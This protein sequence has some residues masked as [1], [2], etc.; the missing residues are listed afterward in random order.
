MLTPFEIYLAK[1]EAHLKHGKA[2][3]HTYR[4]ALENLVGTLTEH[5]RIF[6]DPKHI[7]CGAPDFVVERQHVPLGYIETKNIGEDLDKVEK[8]GQL[9]RYRQALNNLVLTDYLEFR[10]YVNGQPKLTARIA[11]RQPN[12]Q[13]DMDRAGVARAQQ[14]FREFFQ[15][16]APTVAS[17]R[18]LAE[19]M[20]Q[21]A[22]LMRDLIV[23][24]LQADETPAG[25]WHQQYQI[26]QAQLLPKLKPREFADIYAQTMAYGL[27]AAWASMPA[28][29][30]FS[31]ASAY[32]YLA[33]NR[34]L[35]KLFLD[36]GEEMEG[37]LLAPFLDDV[38]A[39]LAHTAPAVLQ[40]FGK[41]PH[42]EDP[43]VHFYETFLAAYDPQ[44]RERRGVYYTPEPAVLFIVNS[45]QALLK[46][47]L[48]RAQGLADKDVFLLDPA[49][50]TSTFLYFVARAVHDSLAEKKQLG[51]W[52]DYVHTNLLPRLIGFEL[53]VA[54]YV[55]AHLKLGLLLRELQYHWQKEDRLR[56]FLTNALDEGGTQAK[57]LGS[58]LEWYISQEASE[59][60]QVKQHT[61]IM[62][63]LGNPPYA[64]FGML[65]KNAWISDL[66]EEYKE[67]LNEKKVN[68][69]DDYIK[70]IR[71]GQWRITQQ[72]QGILAFVTNNSFLDGLTHRRMRESLLNTFTDIYILNLHGSTKKQE[73]TPDGAKDENIFDIQQGVAISVFVKEA[74]KAGPARVH[75]AELWGARPAKYAFLE[76]NNVTTVTWQSLPTLAQKS[77]LG[78]FWFFTP[79]AFDNI[80]EYCAGWSLKDIFP[81]QQNGIKTDRDDLFF[82]FDRAP[83]EKRMKVF[84]SDDG[85]LPA[86]RAQYR[87][88]NSSSYDL[89]RRRLKTKFTAKNLRRCL[90]RPFDTRWLYYAP[91]L[92]SRPA[93][94]VMQHF[95]T[96]EN[97]GLIACRQ[98]AAQR[99]F[100]VNCTNQ[101]T[102]ISSQP[103]AP[104]NIFPLYL[105]PNG[106]Y[107]ATLLA[108]DNGRRPNFAD[109]FVAEFAS[110]LSLTFTPNGPG[111]LKKTFGPEDVFHYLYAILHA[112]TYRERYAEFLKIDFPRVPL[113][114]DKKLF[115]KLATKGATLVELH[116]LRAAALDN[117]ITTYPVAGSNRVEKVRYEQ[118]RV[119]INDTQYFG[120]V[121]EA[122]WE[123][124]VGGYQVCDKWL[125]DRKG[126]ELT[127]DDVLHYQRV[128]VALKETLRVMTEINKT[129]PAWPPA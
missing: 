74:G 32:Q 4:S 1:I 29:A 30:T 103:Y 36:V 101:L 15:T 127:H 83:L 64:N 33:A 59:A 31:R 39:L 25:S 115:A 40:S 77:C 68:L 81:I 24:A 122:V 61:P 14:L 62:V 124:H 5:V 90:Y 17:P 11:T 73:Q 53:L 117:F 27:F 45:V 58:G 91:G 57:P 84:Y 70:F 47:P 48:G 46:K 51:A 52:Q 21:L 110:K 111:D 120:G 22:K 79:K 50:G 18:D 23:E 66:L 28:A 7:A 94:E 87:V 9:Q 129:I 41:P 106:D 109:K 128:V 37:T 95:V 71:F 121:P 85:L 119:W 104:L 100:T 92:T 123:F 34:F 35:R 125:K 20:A 108:H 26:F 86:F 8:S 89:L 3:E 13:L 43:V 49:T 72:G 56:V 107:P 12:G 54:P 76:K 44:L 2:T 6:N 67:G 82:D 63:V 19:R 65:N 112:P 75:Y 93:W 116:L 98:F 105:Y 88:E 16:Q 97:L 42:A 99:H 114:S 55:I 113:T 102:E 38:A 96:G 69:D 126:R 118:K 78:Q 10:W 60:T 80:D